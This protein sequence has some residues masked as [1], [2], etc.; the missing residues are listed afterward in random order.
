MLV[1]VSAEANAWI[2]TLWDQVETK[3][4]LSIDGL[5]VDDRWRQFLQIYF[6]PCTFKSVDLLINEED[7]NPK[8]KRK[9]HC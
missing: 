6:L 9:G 4:T 5:G 1:F 8:M 2:Q 3:L 7:S